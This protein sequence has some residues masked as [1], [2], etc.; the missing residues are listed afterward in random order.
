M[1]RLLVIAFALAAT[2]SFAAQYVQGPHKTTSDPNAY[3]RVNLRAA[4]GAEPA[5]LVKLATDGKGRSHIASIEITERVRPAFGGRSFGSIGQYELIL[6]RAHGL[7]D[8][9]SPRNSGV[10]DLGLAPRNAQGLVEY[11]FDVAFLK[12]I[13]SAKANGVAILEVTNR[14]RPILQ[15]S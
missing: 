13:D 15:T 9:L 14:G 1:K 2:G 6:G 10:V 4:H 5:N 12:P 3:N 11:S 7:A 8:P